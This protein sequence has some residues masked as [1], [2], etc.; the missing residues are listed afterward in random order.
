MSTA[1]V[2][3]DP[4]L[5]RLT[6]IARQDRLDSERAHAKHLASEYAVV[7]YKQ[8]E[9]ARSLVDTHN[10]NPSSEL[11]AAWEPIRGE[12]LHAV[13]DT[14]WRVWIRDI[15]PHCF[16]D[17]VW[18]LACPE[19]TYAWIE[20]RFRRL[21]ER[22]AGAPVRLVICDQTTPKEGTLWST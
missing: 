8:A 9:R 11:L 12:M 21:W 16:R 6:A 1:T 17:G 22:V 19:G 15:H 4:V 5:R 14:T 20:M 18:W 2:D 10:A 7:E 13:D 3:Q